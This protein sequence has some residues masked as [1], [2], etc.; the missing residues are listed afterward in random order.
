MNKKVLGI[1]LVL[2]T[3]TMFAAPMVGTVQAWGCERDVKT[4]TLDPSVDPPTISGGIEIIAPTEKFYDL[5]DG[6]R[7]RIAHGALRE[8]PY[9]G[10]LGEGVLHLKTILSVGR[11]EPTQYGD[12]YVQAKGSGLYQITLDIT[13]ANPDE[14][15]GTGTFKGYAYLKW[16]NNYV[17][18]PDEFRYDEWWT[19]SL[20]GNGLKVNAEAYSTLVFYPIL[21]P[22]YV[23][24]VYTS[25]WTTTTIIS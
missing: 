9:V 25:W 1:T 8:M 14:N 13:I 17:P 3:V 24:P 2:L 20:C 7:I 23:V 16:D 19:I 12:P 10:E 18:N 6:S 11:Q 4:V 5:A 22:P 15:Y 21:E